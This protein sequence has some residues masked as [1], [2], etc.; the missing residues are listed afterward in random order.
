M[1]K[2]KQNE[3]KQTDADGLSQSKEFLGNL[4]VAYFKTIQ[5]VPQGNNFNFIIAGEI[6][7]LDS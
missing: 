4:M 3:T 1:K 2:T 7:M 5:I 6:L